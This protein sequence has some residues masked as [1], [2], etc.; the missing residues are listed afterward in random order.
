M[1]DAV[2]LPS[3]AEYVSEV[4]LELFRRVSHHVLVDAP[5]RQRIGKVVGEPAAEH[6]AQRVELE[7]HAGHNAE[8]AAA[9][10]Q[11]PEEIR[12]LLLARFQHATVGC[13]HLGGEQVVAGEAEATH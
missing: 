3:A 7:V 10:A 1:T 2:F 6:V 4:G 12:V 9:A 11:R 5:E 8:V 13:H